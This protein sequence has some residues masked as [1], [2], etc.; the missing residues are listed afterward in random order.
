[1]GK[2]WEIVGRREE[3]AESRTEWCKRMDVRQGTVLQDAD[4]YMDGMAAEALKTPH[5]LKD[6]EDHDP[7][8]AIDDISAVIAPSRRQQ[9]EDLEDD[10]FLAEVD[11]ILAESAEFRIGT[12]VP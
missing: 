1:M 9:I 3:G 12:L 8:L 6:M 2:A 10:E 5:A 4:K 7:M 11:Q